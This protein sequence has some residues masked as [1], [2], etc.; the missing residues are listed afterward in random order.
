MPLEDSFL[1]INLQIYSKKKTHKLLG[2]CIKENPDSLNII[3]FCKYLL[4][5]IIYIYTF[6]KCNTYYLIFLGSDGFLYSSEL[7]A[8]SGCNDFPGKLLTEITFVNSKKQ[9]TIIQLS[10]DCI[11]FYGA[12]P[13]GDG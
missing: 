7:Y 9:V 8:E 5:C 13:Q 11:G 6:F 12:E 10:S 3:T 1:P 2:Y 4:I